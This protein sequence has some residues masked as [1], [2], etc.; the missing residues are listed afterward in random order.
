MNVFV[1]GPRSAVGR[2]LVPG[3]LEAGHEVVGLSRTPEGARALGSLGIRGVA[4]AS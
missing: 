3:L 2:R 1:A 4:G